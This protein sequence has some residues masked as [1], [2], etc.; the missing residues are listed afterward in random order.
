MLLSGSCGLSLHDQLL[1]GDFGH[2]VF[3]MVWA[4]SW[5]SIQ[6]GLV[7]LSHHFAFFKQALHTSQ[8]AQGSPLPYVRPNNCP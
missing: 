2:D 1:W 8:F 4:L 5:R 7:W 6:L 3:C